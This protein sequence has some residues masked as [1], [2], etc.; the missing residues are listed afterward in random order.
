MP[1]ILKQG[2]AAKMSKKSVFI[3]GLGGHAKVIADAIDVGSEFKLEAFVVPDDHISGDLKEKNIVLESSFFMN[4][5]EMPL[6]IIGIGD[7]N[8][9]HKVAQKITDTRPDVRFATIVHPSAV[10]SNSSR[11]GAGSFINAGVILNCDTVLG[12]HVVVNTGA[13]LDHDCDLSD[14]VSIGPGAILGGSVVIGKGAFVAL[15][16]KII[17]GT[18]LGKFSLLA[19][20]ST[21][22]SDA[23]DLSIYMGTPAKKTSN[24][25]QQDRFL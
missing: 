12:A 24:R 16:S 10:I 2:N 11:L 18:K 9:R 20:G 5:G 4:A 22:I 6:V 17:Q 13:I 1:F 19:A 23:D 8:L 25:N 14:F 15:G 3:F 7:N 21:L